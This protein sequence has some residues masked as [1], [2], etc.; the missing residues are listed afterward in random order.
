VQ[1]NEGSWST[2]D[3]TYVWVTLDGF[4]RNFIP[5]IVR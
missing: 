2:P 1:D 3:E 4:I 5:S